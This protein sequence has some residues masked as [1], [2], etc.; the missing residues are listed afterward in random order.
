MRFKLYINISQPSGTADAFGQTTGR[1][2]AFFEGLAG[3]F[4]ISKDVAVLIFEDNIKLLREF[5][6]N[7]WREKLNFRNNS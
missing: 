5:G 2:I 3:V 4:K 7:H 6:L 1:L